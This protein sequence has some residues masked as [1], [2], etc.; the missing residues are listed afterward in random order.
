MKDAMRILKT[1]ISSERIDLRV[2]QGISFSAGLA[3]IVLAITGLARLARTPAEVLI[4]VL[5]A[6]G[7]GMTFI[8]M[9]LVLGLT[10]EV[11]K[12]TR[13]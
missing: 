5:C 7:A 6:G 3:L 11:R 2:A 4:G 9:G 1:R 13:E 8:N 12:G 10:A